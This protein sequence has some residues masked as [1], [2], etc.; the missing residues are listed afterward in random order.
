[1]AGSYTVISETGGARRAIRPPG[2]DPKGRI[3]STELA[4]DKAGGAVHMRRTGYFLGPALAV[5]IWLTAPPAGMSVAAW[6]IVGLAAWMTSWWITEAVPIPATSILPPIVMPLLGVMPMADALAPYANPIMALLFG[7]MVVA[8]ALERWQL[9]RRLALGVLARVGTRPDALLAGF[10]AVS[11]FLSMWL[12]NSATT[13]MMMPI[14]L[15]V[16]AVVAGQQDGGPAKPFTLALLLGIAYAASLGGL[17]TLIGTPPNA[18]AVAYLRQHFGMEIGFLDWMMV[19]LPATLLL[20]PAVWL[21]LRLM[22]AMPARIGS[23]GRA[24]IADQLA[25]MGAMTVPEKRVAWVSLAM[26]LAWL[27]SRWLRELPGLGGLSDSMIAILGALAVLALPSGLRDADE[28]D[29]RLLDWRAT[30]RL[31]W[32][33]LLLFGGGLSLATGMSW[34]GL[35]AWLGQQLAMLAGMPVWLLLTALVAMVVFLTELTSNT[36][37]TAALLPV[38]GALAGATGLDPLLLAAPAALAATCAFMMPVATGPNAIIFS[39]GLISIPQMARA[40]IVLN[41][42]AIA[43]L[44]PLGLWVAPMIAGR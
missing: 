18:M 39:S 3:I 6:Q 17:A 35:A 29:R 32:G 23:E 13:M 22:F 19:G 38:L 27:S 20:V 7:G 36:A 2:F 31:N 14:A 9:H 43:V 11:A 26:A 37:T 42:I 24:Y 10:M 30:S 33:L 41:F 15:S 25:A 12:S 28:A 1:M 34:S 5:A 40:G 44:V 4:E 16:A 8:L 21:V